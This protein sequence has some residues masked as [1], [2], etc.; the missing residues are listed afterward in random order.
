MDAFTEKN[1][2]LASMTSFSEYHA[3]IY[4]SSGTKDKA[5]E[6]RQTKESFIDLL[7]RVYKMKR[8]TYK[9]HL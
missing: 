7:I 2:I 6:L 9:Q 1:W 8:Y 3:H 5:K 4:F